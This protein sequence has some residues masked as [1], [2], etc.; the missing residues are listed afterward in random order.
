M[1][2][3]FCVLLQEGRVSRY[4]FIKGLRDAQS[5]EERLRDEPFKTF[6]LH[7]NSS[8]SLRFLLFH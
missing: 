7:V 6:T 3:Q 1:L 5:L 4:L 8:L 2:Q